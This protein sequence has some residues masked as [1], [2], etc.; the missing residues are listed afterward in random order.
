VLVVLEVSVVLEV[1]VVLEMPLQLLGHRCCS[2]YHS[3]ENF[4]L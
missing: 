1:L 2:L 4:L 3:S